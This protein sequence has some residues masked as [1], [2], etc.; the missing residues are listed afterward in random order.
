MPPAER[1]WEQAAAI[2]ASASSVA[3][4]CHVDP[5]G[6]AL[7]SMLALDRF[8]RSR[9]VRTTAS[10]GTAVDAPDDLLVIPPQYT[11]LPFLSALVTPRQ[12]PTAPPV[13]VALDTGSAS[14]LGSLRDAAQNAGTLIVI[15]HH[16]SGAPF[17]DVR[18][19]DGEAAA[20]AVL[21][22]E[23]LHRMGGSLDRDIA[24]CLYVGLLT[25]TGSFQYASTTPRVLEL[26]ARL[27]SHDIDP[28]AISRR[29]YATHSFGY[30]KLLGRAL[31]RA[32]LVADVGLL[33][34]AVGQDDLDEFGVALQET[35]GLIDVLRGVEAAECTM[36]SKQQSDGSWR[37]SLR[38]R[39]AVD[40]GEVA[41]SLGGGGHALLAGFVADD[42][43]EAVRDRVVSLLRE[44][45]RPASVGA[46]P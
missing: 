23:L 33:W 24:T 28:A 46:S 17:G 4:A 9:G 29:V 44:K 34:T 10:W 40:V 14:R 43:L 20:T 21:V 42:G 38:S 35:E 22:D 11:F 13:M 15:D 45:S 41:T 3:L 32:E 6:D 19:V 7:G 2:L 18:L 26:A 12:F 37:T 31:Q 5:D 1:D 25:D 27:V 36:V 8:L 16:A 39:G 30:L